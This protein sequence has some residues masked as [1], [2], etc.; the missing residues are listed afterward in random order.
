MAMAC[1]AQL[2]ERRRAGLFPS[3]ICDA[4]FRNRETE[5]AASC[6]ELVGHNGGLADRGSNQLEEILGT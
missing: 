3:A 6:A 1:M 5:G 4:K 2:G